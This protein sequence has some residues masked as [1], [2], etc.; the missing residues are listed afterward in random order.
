MPVPVSG[1]PP[2]ALQKRLDKLGRGHL[3]KGYPDAW[4]GS[5]HLYV[6]SDGK[7]HYA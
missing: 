6:E 2:E 5:D 1:D 7:N 4:D 3:F